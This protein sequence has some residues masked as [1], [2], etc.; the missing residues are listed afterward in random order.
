MREV[1]GS[2]VRGGVGWGCP[3][4]DQALTPPPHSHTC[5]RA[6]QFWISVRRSKRARNS[7]ISAPPRRVRWLKN[8]SVPRIIERANKGGALGLTIDQG[9]GWIPRTWANIFHSEN[10]A[11]ARECRNKN[12]ISSAKLNYIEDFFKMKK[13]QWLFIWRTRIPHFKGNIAMHCKNGDVVSI[14]WNQSFVFCFNLF[15]SES[16]VS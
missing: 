1:W 6:C 10:R 8:I 16:P 3:G 13:E 11:L 9:S 2:T 5:H 12:T 4:V 15:E 7:P 14:V